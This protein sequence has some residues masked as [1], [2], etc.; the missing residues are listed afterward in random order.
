MHALASPQHGAQQLGAGV[1]P[2]PQALPTRLPA[3]RASTSSRQPSRFPLAGQR[4]VRH[5]KNDSWV[6]SFLPAFKLRAN[7]ARCCVPAA[8]EGP[9]P[10]LP[11]TSQALAS[12]TCARCRGG[13]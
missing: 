9:G 13:G 5:K 11:T 4:Q 1:K 12:S 8:W 10:I 2:V 6:S 7:T 3:S